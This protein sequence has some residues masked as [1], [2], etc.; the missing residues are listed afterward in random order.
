MLETIYKFSNEELNEIETLK[1]RIE[2]II[3]DQKIDNR[4]DCGFEIIDDDYLRFSLLTGFISITLDSL[5][6][7]DVRLFVIESFIDDYSKCY[8]QLGGEEIIGELY[9]YTWM[10]EAIEKILSL[11]D[12]HIEFYLDRQMFLKTERSK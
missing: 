12:D 5:K 7:T 6:N 3:K 4:F 9:F 8:T 10:P 2:N 1:N 11:V